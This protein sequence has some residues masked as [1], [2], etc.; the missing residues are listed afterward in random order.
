MM[1]G[2]SAPRARLSGPAWDIAARL[3]QPCT[4]T[5]ARRQ[6]RG[7]QFLGHRVIE[8]NGALNGV[9]TIVTLVP[10]RK[11]GV[12]VFANKQLTVLP[13]AVRAEFLERV[14]GRSGRDL[15]KQIRGE[16]AAWNTLVAIPK[17]PPD[18]K[19][20]RRALSAFTGRFVSPFYGSLN[21][22]Q[23]GDSLLVS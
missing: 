22:V 1:S 23:E 2:I 10:E 21:V 9:R 11:I 14:L 18:A 20:L 16:Q 15:Q 4:G 6:G 17:P 3:Q 19:P 5:V 7:G 13:E 12:A 8:K